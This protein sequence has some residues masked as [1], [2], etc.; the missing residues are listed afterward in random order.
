MSSRKFALVALGGTF[1]ILHKG[2]KSLLLTAFKVADEVIIGLSTDYLVKKIV[3]KHYVPPYEIRF[4]NLCRFLAEKNLIHRARIVP[5]I[6][7]Y[8]PSIDEDKLEAIVVSEEGYKRA[9]EINDIRICCNLP[10][11]K[12]IRIEMIM[13]DDGKPLSCTRILHGEINSEGHIIT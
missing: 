2:H 9:L 10:P 7:P 3:K 8:G 1:S 4:R 6:D 12:I 11:L 13:A 5:L